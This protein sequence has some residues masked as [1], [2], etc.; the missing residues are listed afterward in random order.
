MTQNA[1]VTRIMDRKNAEVCVTRL[2]ACGGNCGGCESCMLSS[3]VKVIAA[4]EIGAKPGQKVVLES[5]SRKIY[6]ALLLVYIMPVGLFLAGY[7]L[8]CLAGFTEGICIAVSFFALL[9]SAVILILK[10]KK[11]N[12]NESEFSY[13]IIRFSEEI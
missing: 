4:N 6:K 3:E 10:Y 13:S 5:S 12:G 7:F 9:I 11:K 8:A 1:I 2:T